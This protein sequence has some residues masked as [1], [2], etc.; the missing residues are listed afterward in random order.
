MSP[1]LA[2]FLSGLLFLRMSFSYRLRARASV[3]AATLSSLLAAPLMFAQDSSIDLEQ[4][5]S[6]LIP[7]REVG[8]D[9]FLA[10]NPNYDGRGVIIAIFDTGVDPSA[11]DLQI[12]TTGER[13][14]VDII[15]GSGAGDVKMSDPI[16]PND[17]DFLEGL[18][19]VELKLPAEVTNPSGEFRV[20]VKLAREMFDRSVLARLE[21][22]IQSAWSAELSVKRQAE[23][24]EVDEA[25]E[26]AL[27]K[28][29]ADRSREELNLIAL[30]EAKKA[31]DDNYATSGPGVVYDCVLWHD[32]EHWRVVVDTNRNGDLGDDEQLRP[33][34][35]A[36][37]Y[38]R[39]DEFTNAT[40]GVQ[41]YEQ[42]RLLSIVTTGD[43]H[44]THVASIAAGHDPEM[45]SRNGIAPGARIV[46]VQIGDVRTWGSSY[47][48][49]ER[50]AL[51]AVAR[52]GVDMT[53]ISFGGSSTYQDGSDLF[54]EVMNRMVYSYDILTVMSAGNE[55]PALSTA[56]SAGAEADFVL[57]VGAYASEEMGKALY[58]TIKDSPDAAFQFTSR[59]PTKDGD[60]GVDIMA[61]GAAWASM[62]S[63]TVRSAA[64]YSG[65]SMA[66]PSATGVAALV[67]SAARQNDLSPRP[68]LLRNALMR[69][70]S[71][72]PGEGVF[73]TGA[74]LVNANGAW[75]KLQELAAYPEFDMF[76]KAEV[77][78]GTFVDEGRGVYL[79]QSI[80]ELQRKAR[81]DIGPLWA[82]ST[83]LPERSEF[84]ADYVL[85]AADDWIEVAD[86][87]HLANDSERVR[88]I[89][90]L[91]EQTELEQANG[92]LLTSRID[93]LVAGAEELGP[94]FSV[95]IT[96]VRP[97]A[98]EVFSDNKLETSINLSPAVT[99]RRFFRVP[100]G[101]HK[102]HVTA[103]HRA[104][105]T[106][107]RGF[108]MQAVS[109]G[110]E[111]PY[112]A[113]QE[114]EWAWL[115]EGEEFSMTADVLPGAVVELAINQFFTSVGSAE[116][117]LELEW[118]GVGMSSN[119]IAIDP[120]Q[121]YHGIEFVSPRDLDVSVEAELTD[122]VLVTLPRATE[123]FFSDERGKRP[124]TPMVPHPE[125][126]EDI[127][128]TYEVEF[129]EETSARLLPPLDYD[130]F[131]AFSG[132]RYRVLHESG[133]L[134][135]Q[136]FGGRRGELTFPAGK[137]TVVTEIST[138]FS[139]DLERFKAL[140]L[141]IA[142]PLDPAIS[143]PVFENE[144]SV[145]HG[146]PTTNVELERGRQEILFLKNTAVEATKD[147]SPS[148]A[149]LRG[150][151]TFSTQDDDEIVAVPLH[152][153][154][155][156]FPSE[157][158][159]QEPEA[160]PKDELQ[161]PVETLNE[162]VHELHMAFVR[163]HRLSTDF[164]IGSRRA[165]LLDSM[166]AERPEDPAPLIE[167]SI[168][169]AILAGLAS[170]GWGK[171]P[172]EEEAGDDPDSDAEDG[173]EEPFVK[174]V[175]SEQQVL[176]WLAQAEALSDADGISRFFGAKPVALP[177]D[178]A[179]RDEIA[180]EEKIWK[181][182]R[183]ALA[184]VVRLR[185][186]IH[187]AAGRMEE[188]WLSWAELHRWEP[189]QHDDSEALLSVLY[190]DAG[191]MGLALEAL[192]KRISDDPL[193]AK[194]LEERIELYRELGWDRH[195]EAEERAL[196]VRKANLDRIEVL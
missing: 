139:L 46:S 68:A 59:G 96:V 49:G 120:N 108:M 20:G 165:A 50:R 152:A 127:R 162:E 151:V 117:E 31:L 128:L 11:Q 91:P 2:Q 38:D 10:E 184:T 7:K 75:A 101:M 70:S 28:A 22:N 43:P 163:E 71:P 167:R 107:M 52:L 116:I 21:E 23:E 81:A 15:D 137:S 172:E 80:D 142:V 94:V 44:G 175:P 190:A 85:K 82:E 176:A 135:H 90:N 32:G 115:D 27:E 67:L 62:S 74:G 156:E 144:K 64:M 18:S 48:I 104:D 178:L 4:M 97:A 17:E 182:K 19:G 134:L 73:T 45:P 164:E 3:L 8:A 16:S 39:F 166:Q 169:G 25:L 84:E 83:S 113:Y 129:E 149:Y 123:V 61:P 193:N 159:D 110:A 41:V 66:A 157:V 87:V 150:E 6:A 98:D 51:A 72:I 192:N 40:F 126:D 76:Y 111:T 88:F 55:G 56:G 29:A 121:D 174:T 141:R 100:E 92:G 69:G 168:E 12:T 99:A 102:L 9:A 109:V 186:D 170:D 5:R 105:D 63:E 173:K 42:G 161:T 133:K 103:R 195:A 160:K 136:N 125:L 185:T 26:S 1:E 153:F 86:F 188:A 65:T 191:L 183:E 171:L 53:N 77:T 106:I 131:E 119:A 114:E 34:G 138:L 143:L 132:W 89:M 181:E 124:P 60:I 146:G 194:L 187:R 145:L 177:G 79:R 13:K 57:G 14:I 196:A 130:A 118:L 180:A 54:S 189:E 112:S 95:P 158:T 179:T 154:A 33:F 30:H 36:G 147:L 148:P 155:G 35:V 24:S 122:A 140:P 37:E 58:T 93:G 78:G 47:G